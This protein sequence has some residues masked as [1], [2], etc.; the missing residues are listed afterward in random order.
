L[1]GN[2]NLDSTGSKILVPMRGWSE[3]DQEKGPLFDLQ[4]RDAF[5][6]TLQQALDPHMEVQ[7]VDFHINDVEFARLAAELMDGM[8]REGR[9]NS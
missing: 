7:K 2:L 5:L 8:I 3:A 1:A 9:E 4:M 6:E